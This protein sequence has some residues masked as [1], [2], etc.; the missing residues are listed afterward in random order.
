MI[1]LVPHSGLANRIRVIVSGL[2]FSDKVNH[3]LTIIWNKDKSLYCSFNDLFEKNDKIIVKKKSFVL[4]SI[5]K[6]QNSPLIKKAI[7]RLF[8][9]EFTL[10]DSNVKDFVWSTGSNLI[11]YKKLPFEVKN[12]FFST[13][14]EFHF[15]SAYL[16]LLTPVKSILFEIN[17]NLSKFTSKTVG[18]HI[19]RT[20]HLQAILESPLDAFVKMMLLELTADSEISFYLA[21]DDPEVETLL[22]NKFPGKIIT[23]K[24]KYSRTT[25]KGIQDAMVDLYSLSHTCKI[26]GSYFSSFSDLAS[27]IGD[28]P[29]I[30]I[31]KDQGQQ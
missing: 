7:C 30:V 17:K 5:I 31:R 23:Y 21:S 14:H 8:S 28:I 25:V 6:A 27:R 10:F 11:D 16:K 9:I 4:K 20:D 12:Y 2:S 3:Q 18:V 26:Y 24:K 15:E 1:Y 19:R 22:V 29:L 13:C